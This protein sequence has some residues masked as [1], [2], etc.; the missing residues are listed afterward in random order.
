M[1]NLIFLL[2]QMFT[3][4]EDIIKCIDGGTTQ[5]EWDKTVEDMFSLAMSIPALQGYIALMQPI[6]AF[7][8]I[9]FPM[10]SDVEKYFNNTEKPKML[11]A[12]D[13]ITKQDLIR[14]YYSVKLMTDVSA[15]VAKA[16]GVEEKD[17]GWEYK[18]YENEFN[19]ATFFDN[20]TLG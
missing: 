16:N 10:I 8:K 15:K 4:G 14:S 6:L 2:P 3:V 20:Q 7:A 12:R 1:F 19:T 9:A 18:Y 5:E 13:Q 17:L 11:A